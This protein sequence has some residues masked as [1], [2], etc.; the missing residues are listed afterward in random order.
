MKRLEGTTGTPMD[1]EALESTPDGLAE[2]ESDAAVAASQTQRTDAATASAGDPGTAPAAA[3]EPAA[4]KTKN[5]SVGRTATRG[6]G[7]TVGAQLAR[8][9]I[10]MASLVV[11]S[12]LLSPGQFGL[13]AM[14]TSIVNVADI[15]RDFG[16]S[17]AA[18]QSKDITLGERTNLFWTNLGIGTVCSL[19][20]AGLAPLLADFYH[21]PRVKGITLA[22]AG[23]FI[24]SG[25]NTQHRADLARSLRFGAL[26]FTDVT[27]QVIAVV[28]SI[29]A[30]ALGAGYW[31]IVI[32][33]VLMVAST[34]VL[35]V[36]QTR[37]IP[38]LPR[39]DASIRRFLKFG[40][41]V[42]GTNII[43]Y[44]INNVDNVSI[45]HYWGGYDLG[46]YSRAFNLLQ[47]P[48]TQINAPLGRVA[49]PLLSKYQDDNASMQRYYARFQGAVVY[50]LGVAFGIAAALSTPIVH[51][52]LGSKWH[53]AGPIFGILALSGIFKAIDSASY[54]VWLAKGLTGRLMKFYLV[55]RPVM[56]AMILAGLPWGPK[57]VA[58]GVLVASIAHWA[59]STWYLC[60]CAHL[61]YRPLMQ[62]SLLGILVVIAPA[63]A[64]TWFVQH[65]F[66][67]PLLAVLAGGIEGLVWVALIALLNARVRRDLGPLVRQVR[68]AMNRRR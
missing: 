9:V 63:T 43:G 15:I 52:M 19:I 68:G 2:L 37:W 66:A 1:A 49:L 36:V 30:A 18:I 27:A 65:A 40:T 21:E 48:M 54:Q 31:A 57:G 53:M 28:G 38:G 33:Q 10:Q 34:L 60:R 64:I 47:M 41:G 12:H 55:S 11:L 67:N 46:Y 4:A 17:S 22:L 20:V 32:Q 45:G 35:N 59:V 58:I 7:V 16:L 8:M 29:T 26:A 61:D 39:R 5:D 50:T 25:A 23:L 13:V 62:A 24:L 6:A 42:L 14:V 56:I 3:K 51:I 44:V